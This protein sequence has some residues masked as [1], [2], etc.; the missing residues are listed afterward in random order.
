MNQE[1]L[2]PSLGSD[3]PTVKEVIKLANEILAH[4]GFGF[5]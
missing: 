5:R 2:V 1:I 4:H 3:N